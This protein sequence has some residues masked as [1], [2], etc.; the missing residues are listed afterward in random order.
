[1]TKLLGDVKAQLGNVTNNRKGGAHLV[2]AR[3]TDVIKTRK[4]GMYM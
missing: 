4:D 1:M 2:V 3:T